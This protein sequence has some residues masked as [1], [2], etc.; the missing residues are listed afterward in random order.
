VKVV[1]NR[2]SNALYFSRSAIPFARDSGACVQYYRHQ[3]IYGYSRKFLLQFIRWKPTILEKT[4]QLEQLRALENGAKIRVLV[5]RKISLGV[6]APDDVKSITAI[7][8][9]S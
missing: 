2:A 6:D 7:L 9:K 4:E 1:L 8:K 5:T 3:G